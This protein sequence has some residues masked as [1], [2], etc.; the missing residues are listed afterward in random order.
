MKLLQALMLLAALG[1]AVPCTAQAVAF[2]APVDPTASFLDGIKA[3][4]NGQYEQA[5]RK[6]SAVAEMQSLS[7]A[8]CYNLGNAWFKAG[9]LG[10]AILWWERGLML[11]PQDPDMRFNLEHAR[12]LVKDAPE[13]AGSGVADVLFFPTRLL[14]P[15][16]VQWLAL[17]GSSLFWFSCAGLL[18]RRRSRALQVLR[19]AA[20]AVV[21]VF[22][23]AALQR[24]YVRAN[25][26]QAVVLEERL[27][28]RAGLNEEAA[29]LFTLH[30]GSPVQVKEKRDGYVRILFGQDKVGWA[31]AQAVGMIE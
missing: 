16:T 28:V 24:L 29:Q 3:Y 7:G 27:P 26:S 9:E 10:K 20:L 5:A 4:E 11:A 30:A 23:P 22:L 1:L 2:A 17:A 8:L 19:L 21:L 12:S 6:F 13:K 14:S 18:F 15:R 25:P 31:P